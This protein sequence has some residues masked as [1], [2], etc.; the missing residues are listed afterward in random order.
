MSLS[1]Y[2]FGPMSFTRAYINFKNRDDI[3]KF[4]DQFDGYCF[5]DS[6]GNFSNTL[7]CFSCELLK[8]TDSHLVSWSASPCISF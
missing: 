6:R 2:S 1:F 8:E 7:H 5:V 3:I 4:R